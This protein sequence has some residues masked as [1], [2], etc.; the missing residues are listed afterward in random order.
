MA[1]I[2]DVK[3]SISHDH[4][5]KLVEPIVK[6]KIRFS[7]LELCMMK[8]CS[9]G[10]FFKLKCQLWGDDPFSDDFLYT[11][12]TV[13]Y[14]PDGN[15]TSPESRTFKVVLGEGVLDEDWLG[16]DE[17][18]GKLILQNLFSGTVISRKSNVVSHSF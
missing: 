7:D 12:S 10:R 6:C 13:Y 1:S 16:K 11:Y 18:Y 9:K 14:F 17:I 5:K 3:L 8:N 15:P 4:K 2:T